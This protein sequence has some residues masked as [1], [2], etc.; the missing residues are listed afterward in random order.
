MSRRLLGK[1]LDIAFPRECLSCGKANPE[2]GFDYICADCARETYFI[3]GGACLNCGEIVGVADA[4][5]V[6]GCA[7]CVDARPRFA[8]IRSACLFSSGVRALMLELKYKNGL[9]V[10]DDLVRLVSCM[11]GADEFLSGAILVPVPLHSSR[12]RKRKYNQ[13]EL[14]A[15]RLVQKFPHM[16]LEC[17]DIL[18]RTRSTQ[19]QTMLDKSQRADNVRGAFEIRKKKPLPEKDS[20][21]ILLDDVA[22]T[23]ATM[24][25]CAK[26]FKRAGYK[27]VHAFSVFKRL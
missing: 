26:V 4:P 16:N 12:L 7:A 25:E 14:I 20:R 10:L 6:R 3:N 19:T 9:H 13:S 15:R 2:D 21:I 8:S 11:H 24:D 18:R 22:T 27:N 1:I 17:A 5:F 23:G